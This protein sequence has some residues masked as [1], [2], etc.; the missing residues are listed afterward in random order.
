MDISEKIQVK[1]ELGG[2]VY[3]QIMLKLGKADTFM[4]SLM[5]M[6]LKESRYLKSHPDR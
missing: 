4:S 2:M 5:A 3:H 1:L 6:E